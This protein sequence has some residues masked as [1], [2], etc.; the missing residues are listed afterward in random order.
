MNTC[1]PVLLKIQ[2]V[3]VICWFRLALYV[4]A[5]LDILKEPAW[6]TQLGGGV[7]TGVFVCVG[8]AV[9][10]G[11]SVDVLVGVGVSVFVGV[12]VTVCVADGVTGVGVAGMG[13]RVGDGT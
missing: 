3:K 13:V 10:V 9:G 12:G 5:T 8:V 6:A 4:V 7:G 2:M 1:P 11:V